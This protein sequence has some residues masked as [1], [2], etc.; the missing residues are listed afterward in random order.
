MTREPWHVAL[1]WTALG[2]LLLVLGWLLMY[3]FRG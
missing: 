1:E 3:G 2:V